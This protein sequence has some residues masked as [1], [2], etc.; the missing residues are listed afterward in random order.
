VDQSTFPKKEIHGMNLSSLLHHKPKAANGDNSLLIVSAENRAAIWPE[1]GGSDVPLLNEH[2]QAVM[3]I[4]QHNMR[5]SHDYER[6]LFTP[7]LPVSPELVDMVENFF[8][9]QFSQLR[10]LDLVGVQP[11]TGPCNIMFVENGLPEPR[12]PEWE[13]D[14]IIRNMQHWQSMNRKDLGG[15]RLD[16]PDVKSLR[17]KQLAYVVRSQVFKGDVENY[18]K[19]LD[20]TIVLSMLYSAPEGDWSALDGLE[21][22]YVICH[23]AVAHI[24]QKRSGLIPVCFDFIE[25]GSAF[26]GY[27]KSEYH[28]SAYFMPYIPLQMVRYMDEQTFEPKVAYK[29][30]YGVMGGDDWNWPNKSEFVKVKVL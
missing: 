13:H 27:K 2:Q 21:G 18:S 12:D 15:V 3:R 26:I 17:L 6:E 29:A 19:E 28:A 23:P 16:E 22:A 14:Q 5:R 24:V 9:R 25:P 10:S 7:V 8:P 20:R 30:R 1:I 4:C 11:A